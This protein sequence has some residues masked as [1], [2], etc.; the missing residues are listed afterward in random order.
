MLV[1]V[2]FKLK[3]A[4]SIIK[5]LLDSSVLASGESATPLFPSPLAAAW[6]VPTSA[7]GWALSPPSG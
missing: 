7:D 1:F 2:S 3:A 4:Q 5:H 6:P